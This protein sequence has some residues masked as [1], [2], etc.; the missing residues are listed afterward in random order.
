[1]KSKRT[2]VTIET[3]EIWT[4]RRLGSNSGGWCP[5]CCARV[6]MIT[7]EEA[8]ILMPLE[9]RSIYRQVESGLIHCAERQ[10]GASLVCS[11][12][13]VRRSPTE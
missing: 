5:E 7:R 6:N 10:G 12:S 1:M 2:E 13:G 9:A 11:N 8:A 3:D 4:V